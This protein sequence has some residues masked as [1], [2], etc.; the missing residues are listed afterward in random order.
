MGWLLLAVIGM[1]GCWVDVNTDVKTAP[2]WTEITP[3]HRL[4]PAPVPAPQKSVSPQERA[5]L[6][7]SALSKRTIVAVF[8]IED[9]GVE[10]S[11]ELLSRM[12]DYLAMSL[13]AAGAFQVI[14]RDQL[15]Q[16]LTKQKKESFRQCYEQSCQIEIGRELAAQ[17][18]L[19][20][21]IMKIGSMCLM[22]SVLYDLKR[23]T[24]EGG[25]R[26]EGKCS[27]DGIVGQIKA[28]VQQLTKTG[29]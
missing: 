28:I 2:K 11:S 1:S 27:E 19:A 20:S 24:S 14:P 8:D 6:P 12:S 4:A 13:A 26:A 18:T 10:L 3:R 7:K 16:R 23:A 17:K 22:T 15:H 21:V 5:P 25:A 9:K 29:H